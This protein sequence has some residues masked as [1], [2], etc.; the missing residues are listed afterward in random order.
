MSRTRRR[1]LKVKVKKKGWADRA[2]SNSPYFE[3]LKKKKSRL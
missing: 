1:G 2:L 3:L